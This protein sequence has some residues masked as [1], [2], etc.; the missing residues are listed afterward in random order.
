MSLPFE[1]S[2]IIDTEAGARLTYNCLDFNVL[3]FKNYFYLLFLF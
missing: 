3:F 2:I 1:S